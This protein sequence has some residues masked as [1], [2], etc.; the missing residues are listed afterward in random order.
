MKL[1][2]GHS[3]SGAVI[4]IG[5]VE[6]KRAIGFQV[7]QMI[8]NQVDISWFSVRSQPHDFVFPGINFESKVV[9][10]GTIQQ[11]QRVWKLGFLL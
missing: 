7:D 1:I 2:I 11:A 3:Q 10:K 6:T 5:H 4:K 9:G 8:V